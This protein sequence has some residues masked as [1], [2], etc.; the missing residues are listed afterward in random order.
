MEPKTSNFQKSD[1]EGA[2]LD[3]SKQEFDFRFPRSHSRIS[4]ADQGGVTSRRQGKRLYMQQQVLFRK[5][6]S[7]LTRRE[8]GSVVGMQIALLLR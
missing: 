4:F 5:E 3:A 2:R 8:R 7:A 1:I 6:A